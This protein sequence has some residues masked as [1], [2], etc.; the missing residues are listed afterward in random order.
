M[1][2]PGPAPA[3]RVVKGQPS[4]A[5]VA[6]LTAVIAALRAAR[7][8]HLSS[9]GTH[10]RSGGWAQRTRLVRTPLHPGPGAWRRSASP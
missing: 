3:L 1:G 9:P 7:E 6:A 4:A 2:A 10:R 5:E 8:A